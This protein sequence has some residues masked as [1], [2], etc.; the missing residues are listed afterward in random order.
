MTLLLLLLLLVLLQRNSRRCGGGVREEEVSATA[1]VGRRI[2]A[3]DTDDF[4]SR[5]DGRPSA[6]PRPTRLFVEHWIINAEGLLTESQ[7]AS[8]P[9]ALCT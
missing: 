1:D 6:L 7:H 9:S 5:L 8:T 3:G 2:A 4:F